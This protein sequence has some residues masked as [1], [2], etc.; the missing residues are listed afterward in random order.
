MPS[1][2]RQVRQF[3]DKKGVKLDANIIAARDEMMLT[4]IKYSK[5]EIKGKRA[6]GERATP[7]EPP[8]NRTG[9]LRR[10]IKGEKYRKGFGDY[11]AEVGPTI[12]YGRA[13]EV[14]NQYAPPNWK[15]E[16]R[17]KGFPY[18]KPAFKKFLLVAPAI[19]RKHIL[20]G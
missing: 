19:F 7:G 14:A 13:L 5:E 4:L 9:N 17:V 18:M 3:I 16:S 20:R 10:S 15:G 11:R 6:R 2:I 1:N 12:V 8:M